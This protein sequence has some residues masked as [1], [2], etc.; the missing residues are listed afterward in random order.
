MY[1]HNTYTRS[2]INYQVIFLPT[3]QDFFIVDYFFSYQYDE[4]ALN[5]CV[6]Y[7]VIDLTKVT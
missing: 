3:S 6:I 2:Y 7:F 1:V 5:V 4:N